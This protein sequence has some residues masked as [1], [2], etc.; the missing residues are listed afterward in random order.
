MGSFG[1]KFKFSIEISYT[2]FLPDLS[3][4][5]STNSHL[6]FGGSGK[7]TW[8]SIFV[9]NL[10]NFFSIFVFLVGNGGEVITCFKN[11][12]EFAS[13]E[14]T[15]FFLLLENLSQKTLSR[16][17]KNKFFLFNSRNVQKWRYLSKMIKT[18]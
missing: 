1:V 11:R 18:G 8:F 12:G 15:R 17:N 14:K 7:N 2:N 16:E 3:N 6:T 9:V 4:S 13:C 5:Q 10:C